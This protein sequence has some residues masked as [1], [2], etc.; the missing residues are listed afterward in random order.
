MSSARRR[1]TALRVLCRA[2]PSEAVG[3]DEPPPGQIRRPQPAVWSDVL[4]LATEL[5]VGP[6]LWSAVHAA[7][8][9][10]PLD[11]AEQ[12]HQ[13][14]LMSTVRNI[15]LRHCLTEAVQ[16][17]NEA[18]IVPLLFKGALQLVDGT[19]GVVGDR[20]ITDL[21]LLVQDEQMS[22]A[23]EALER[24]GYEPDPAGPFLHPH[25]LPFIRDRSPGPIELHAALGS[26]P[27]PTALPVTEAWAESSEL[28][29]GSARAQAL[30][31]THQ[32]LHN[33]LHSAVQ[34]LNH[35]VGGLPLRQLLTLSRL[36]Q[37]HGPAIDWVAIQRRMEEH[38]LDSQLRDHLWLA[39]R[40]A[41]MALPDGRW[42]AWP[43]LHELRVRAS[44]A[45]GW[46]PHVQRNLRFAFGRAYLD[47]LYAHGDQP[48]KLV[49][50]RAHHA[51]RILRRDGRRVLGDL[52]AR[53]T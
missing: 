46:P 3:Q 50:A 31:P 45:L 48:V 30:S 24:L 5:H 11:V 27:I 36:V 43:R 8:D 37:T 28:S 41:G 42:R 33:V 1:T 51:F 34:D 44:F 39:H 19:P 6:A 52:R 20:W 4:A 47:S 26:P 14:Q 29:V 9:G 17:F 22:A 13:Y 38:G 49:A 15:R 25:E 10:M 16:A 53:R 35:A 40:F 32:V 18:G 7:R 23:G 12:L 21:D 2:L